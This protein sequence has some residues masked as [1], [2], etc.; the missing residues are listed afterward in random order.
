[1]RLFCHMTVLALVAFLLWAIYI[2]GLQPT[3]RFEPIPFNPSLYQ[4]S[5]DYQPPKVDMQ[6]SWLHWEGNTGEPGLFS[7]QKPQELPEQ[8]QEPPERRVRR[9]PMVPVKRPKPQPKPEP[10]YRGPVIIC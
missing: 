1:M 2:T 3:S 4:P 7:T 9:L 10:Q 6:G 5:E 8:A